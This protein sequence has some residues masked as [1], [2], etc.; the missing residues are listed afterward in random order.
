MALRTPGNDRKTELAAKIRHELGLKEVENTSN[1]NAEQEKTKL[2]LKKKMLSQ[3][4]I[5]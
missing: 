1:V 4:I 2:N 3:K 5:F